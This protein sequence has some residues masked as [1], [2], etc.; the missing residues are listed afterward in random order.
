MNISEP[1]DSFLARNLPPPRINPALWSFNSSS[2]NV[3]EHCQIYEL[4][5]RA[6]SGSGGHS[7]PGG[8]QFWFFIRLPY[9]LTTKREW[10]PARDAISRESAQPA[11]APFY[12][13]QSIFSLPW[14]FARQRYPRQFLNRVFKAYVALR[15]T[16]RLDWWNRDRE[17]WNFAHRK[18]QSVVEEI[19]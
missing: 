17:T 4:N 1:H 10:P 2:Q 16:A 12:L 13:F 18:V 7:N 3:R 19:Q 8:K 9:V 6:W 15:N 11:F 5:S 14:R